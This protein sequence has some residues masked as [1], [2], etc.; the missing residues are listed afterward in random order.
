[1]GDRVTMLR[2]IRQL[3]AIARTTLLEAVQQPAVLLLLLAGTLATGLIPVFQ[4]HRFGEAGRLARDGGL[5]YT[6]VLGLV[7]AASVAGSAIAR[8]CD[9]GTAA[10][11]LSKPVARGPFVL[12]KFGGV[13]AVVTLFW[14]AMSAAT[15]LAERVAELTTTG[16]F[17]NADPSA[18]LT[19]QML[20]L[21]PP[22]ALA[23]AGWRNYRCRRRFGVT[24]FHAIW[25]GLLLACAISE[26]QAAW[27][28][29]AT[30]YHPALN[31]R[32]LPAALLVLAALAV[33]AALATAL[34]TRLDPAPTLIACLAMLLLGIAADQLAASRSL[35]H[36]PLWLIPNLQHFWRAD[37]LAAGGRLATSHVLA[38]LLYAATWCSFALCCATALFRRR[39]VG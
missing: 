9:S 1:M 16:G 6:L 31:W 34:A 25:I 33:F 20:L 23:L 14:L 5:A 37:D 35:R 27:L 26:G 29:R 21:A 17:E 4:F 18:R 22:A 10:A 8:E 11:L 3:H 15:L 32:V 38:V 24:A 28:A 13:L 30:P 39:D 2:S 7:L 36:L 19:G 12:A